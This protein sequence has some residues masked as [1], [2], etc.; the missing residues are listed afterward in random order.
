MLERSCHDDCVERTAFPPTMKA[1]GAALVSSPTVLLQWHRVPKNAFRKNL[2]YFPRSLTDTAEDWQ[3]PL[4]LPM[5]SASAYG[6]KRER[7]FLELAPACPPG[8]TPKSSQRANVV[9]S[10]LSDVRR[11][12]GTSASCQHRSRPAVRSEANEG[13]QDCSKR[14]Y[15]ALGCV[16]LRSVALWCKAVWRVAFAVRREAYVDSYWAAQSPPQAAH[17]NIVLGTQ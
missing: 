17:E 8:Q 11:A 3:R 6:F 4:K 16:A 5:P 13:R 1:G 10:P 2:I 15:V 7:R 12:V 14:P 9:Q